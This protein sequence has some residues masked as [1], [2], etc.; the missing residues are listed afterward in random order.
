MPSMS[1]SKF[2]FQNHG[3]HNDVKGRSRVMSNA[4]AAAY[5]DNFCLEPQKHARQAQQARLGIYTGAFNC[6]FMYVLSLQVV[7]VRLLL[8]VQLQLGR[9]LSLRTFISTCTR[10]GHTESGKAHKARMLIR[11]AAIVLQVHAAQHNTAQLLHNR[12]AMR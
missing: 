1:G 5:C 4:P 11:A 2:H 7:T 10:N 9:P 12:T 3:M 8:P 6:V